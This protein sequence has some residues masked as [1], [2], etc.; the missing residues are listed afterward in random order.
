[1]AESR[2]L[3]DLFWND[4]E[5]RLRALWRLGL[6]TLLLLVGGIGGAVAG[7]VLA[8]LAPGT[9]PPLVTAFVSVIA[10][11]LQTV[12][13]VGGIVVAAWLID[14]RRLVDFGLDRSRAWWADLSFGLALG[15][16]LA[17]LVFA[18]EL[19]AGFLRVTDTT[20]IR[21]ESPFAI[22]SSVP[23]AVA[24]AL[25]FVFFVGV[26]LFEEL[27]FRGYLLANAAEGL[28]GWFGIGRR[29]ALAGA[30]VL[31]S[32]AFAAGHGSNPGVTPL[33]IPN[34]ALFGG[35]LAAS[36]L[37]TDRIAVAL[38]FHVTWNFSIASVFGFPVSGFTTP[39]TVL[40]VEQSGPSLVTG[41]GFG[42]EG[43]LVALVAFVAGVAALAWWVRLREGALRWSAA[44]TRP[45][46]RRGT[47][48]NEDSGDGDDPAGE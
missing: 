26:A 21:P 30:V 48:G 33:A 13:F 32:L 37:L 1:M 19:G 46:L 16:A 39:V 40:V 8:A 44:V 10:R 25:T 5:D 45:T 20:A 34:I 15:V 28:D 24:L 29:G 17:A 2:A 35:L 7:A 42:P 43:G 12:G 6:A 18:I 9:A 23:V 14:R 27:L 3:R 47:G 11:T 31:S 38:G 41:G 4:D 36:V 22:G